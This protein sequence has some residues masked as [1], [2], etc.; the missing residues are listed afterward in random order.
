MSAPLRQDFDP[1]VG[2]I[3]EYEAAFMAYG[4]CLQEFCGCCRV[5]KR[6]HGDGFTI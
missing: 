3:V 5:M 6:G 4:S 1:A 2:D